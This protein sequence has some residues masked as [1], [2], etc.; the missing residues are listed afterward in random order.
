[1]KRYF[2][3][4]LYAIGIVVLIALIMPL[5]LSVMLIGA[6]AGTPYQDL[7]TYLENVFSE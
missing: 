5:V 6:I 4:L 3:N 1:M 7:I 2:K